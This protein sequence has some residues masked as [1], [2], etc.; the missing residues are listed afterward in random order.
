MK[1]DKKLKKKDAILPISLKNW[2]KCCFAMFP[3]V[4]TS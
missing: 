2:L 3:A 1:G 4:N